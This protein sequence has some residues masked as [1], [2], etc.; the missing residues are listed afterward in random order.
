MFLSNGKVQ[1]WGI[2]L[3]NM[4]SQ[5]NLIGYAQTL[6]SDLQPDVVA[7]ED[8]SAPTCRKGKP[9]RTLIAAL[10]ALASHNGVHDVSVP[11][12]R[13]YPSKYE[14]AA[15]LVSAHPELAGYLP[16]QKRRIFDYEPRNMILFE[17]LALAMAALDGPQNHTDAKPE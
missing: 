9:A 13:P 5:G 12:H 10:A 17:A 14:E 3:R 8:I 1:D 16:E 11:R 6:I 15:A 7:T 4:T 2:T